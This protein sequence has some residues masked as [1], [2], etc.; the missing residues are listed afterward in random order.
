MAPTRTPTRSLAPVALLAFSGVAVMGLSGESSRIT[1]TSSTAPF[2]GAEA[3]IRPL[4]IPAVPVSAREP[5]LREHADDVADYTFRAR[6]DA[7]AHA[8]HGEGTIRF[9]NHSA[10]PIRELWLHLYLNAF[11]NERST[12]LREPAAGFRGSAPFSDWGTIDLRA[13]SLRTANGEATDLLPALD[14]KGAGDDETDARVPLP[15]D[16]LPGETITLDVTWDDKLP[17]IV[18]RTGYSGSFHCV[19]QWFPKLARLEPDGTWAHFPFHHLA[20]FYAD[21]GTYDVT[22]DVPEAFTVG[23]TGPVVESTH[24]GGR[25]IERHVQ[26][27]IHDFAWAAW[28]RFRIREEDIDGVKVRVLFPPGFDHDADRE[29]ADMRF[30]IPY[31]GA[32]YGRYPYPVLTLVHPPEA[33]AEAG[34]M[35]YPTFITTGGAWHGVPFTKLI[36]LVTVHEFGHQYFYGLLGSNEVQWP[37]LD[38]GVNS[39]AEADA[40]RAMFGAGSAGEA[41]GLS[42]SDDAIQAVLGNAAAHDGPVAQ[43]AFAFDTGGLYGALVYQRTGA[44]LE[45]LRRV[46]GDVPMRQSL[47]A[48]ALAFRFEHPAPEDFIKAFAS[49][50]GGDAAAMLRRALFEKGWVDYQV[51][52]IVSHAVTAPRGIFDSGG[53]RETVKDAP[54]QPRDFEGWVLVERLG[55]LSLPVEVELRFEDGTRERVPWD[56]VGGS[57]RI[58]FRRASALRAAVIDPEHKVVLDDNF[59]NNHATAAD[60]PCAGAPRTVERAAYWA[61]LFVDGLGP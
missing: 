61:Q 26:G 53:K 23:A 37:F 58:P 43:P 35:E 57:V 42:I 16:V 13:L 52:E 40:L 6:L 33:A 4:V 14:V 10:V 22:L 27:D 18:E 9:R 31:F 12:F 20:E 28:D 39:F 47:R 49:G 5:D 38:E 1:D 17:A 55:T 8:V 51:T 2:P 48:Y 7:A 46:Y 50:L 21:F 32:L 41:S 29:L 3:S 30:A 19:G 24:A 56:G 59:A 60:S 36:D 54:A 44:I 11:K 25:L 34:G 45:T 15:R